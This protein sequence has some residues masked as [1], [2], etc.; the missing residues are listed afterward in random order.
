MISNASSNDDAKNDHANFAKDQSWGFIV[1]CH[2]N[3]Y[4]HDA[5]D[6]CM[7]LSPSTWLFDIG[8]SKHITS[9]R[10]LFTSLADA[11]KEG[12]ATC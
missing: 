8:A 7:S 4:V 2:Y 12:S 5:S 10:S 3:P 6:T 1:Q 11:P 9:C